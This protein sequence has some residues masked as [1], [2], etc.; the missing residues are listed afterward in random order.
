MVEA[1]DE[2]SLVTGDEGVNVDGGCPVINSVR[3]LAAHGGARTHSPV[4]R[5]FHH[6][7]GCPEGPSGRDEGTWA[8]CAWGNAE[9]HAG[10]SQDEVRHGGRVDGGMAVH[11]LAEKSFAGKGSGVDPGLGSHMEACGPQGS[12]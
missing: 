9:R 3:R 4:R 12:R 5:K 8:T 1:R 6:L 11:D 10:V 2:Q 7:L